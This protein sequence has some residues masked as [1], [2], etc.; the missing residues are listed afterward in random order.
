MKIISNFSDYYDV[1]LA[2]GIDEKIRFERKTEKISDKGESSYSLRFKK[3]DKKY[4][5]LIRHNCIF[6]CEKAYPF[7]EAIVFEEI[8][9]NKEAFY[10]EEK[11]IIS[12]FRAEIINF[13]EKTLNKHINELKNYYFVQSLHNDKKD[14]RFNE[15]WFGNDDKIEDS[16]YHCK[17]FEGLPY[18]ERLITYNLP[19]LKKYKFT[20]VMPP[21]E[22]FQKISMYLGALNK[23]KEVV[24]IKDKYLAQGKGFDCYSFKK[25]PS[26]KKAKK[27]KK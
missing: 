9:K 14:K 23:E 18:Q 11:K 16:P 27:C 10:K 12:Y 21:L 4:I 20:Q 6:F 7:V 13:I 17:V 2:Y 26:K 22:A 24:Q 15:I 3:D 19:L 5:L 1:G 8:M 25:M